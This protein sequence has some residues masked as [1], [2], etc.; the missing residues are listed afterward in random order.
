MFGLTTA[1]EGLDDDHAAAAA[2]TRT[3]QYALL[4]G[5][6]RFGRLRLFRGGWRGEQR[7]R[8]REVGSTIGFGKQSVV[9]M[10]CKPLGRTWMRKRR[11]N[12]LVARVIL[13]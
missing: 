5:R 9:G 1:R 10:R 2:R 8:S 3:W 4:V 11:M 13:S 7:A 6:D 12:S